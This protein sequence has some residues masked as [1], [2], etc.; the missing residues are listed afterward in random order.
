MFSPALAAIRH[1]FPQWH[2]SLLAKPA[3]ASL[4]E[5]SP[6]IDDVVVY[7]DPGVHSGWGGLLKL[8]TD[9]KA[10]EYDLA[11][12]FQNALGAAVVA[13]LAGIPNRL[14]Y[15]TD[16]RG[17]LLTHPVTRPTQAKTLPLVQYFRGL[18]PALGIRSD[19]RAPA[20]QIS[21]EED[22]LAAALL[23]KHGVG[24]TDLFIGLNPGSVYGTAKQWSFRRYVAV[25]DRLVEATGAKIIVFGGPGEEGLGSRVAETMRARPI[26]LSGKTTVRELMALLKHCTLLVTNDT[27]PMHVAS[28]LGVPVV[29]IFGPTDPNATAPAGTNHALVT[30]NIGCSPCLLRACPIDHAC[31]NGIEE[32]EVFSAAMGLLKRLQ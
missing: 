25:A 17:W 15:D 4:F 31:M 24:P 3:S 19:E 29:A 21:D 16:G 6:Y 14:G 2:L 11:L 5:R 1:A 13:R 8:A 30:T 12:L 28:A 22:I 32:Q 7:R 18:L 23:Q 9:L 20:L 10:G 26:V 27:G